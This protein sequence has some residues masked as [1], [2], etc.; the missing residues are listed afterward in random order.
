MSS[1][2]CA[3]MVP[4]NKHLWLNCSTCI[5]FKKHNSKNSQFKISLKAFT[6]KNV[7]TP[8]KKLFIVIR[9]EESCQF[10]WQHSMHERFFHVC[11]YLE[12]Q[13]RLSEASCS[14]MNPCSFQAFHCVLCSDLDQFIGTLEY[15]VAVAQALSLKY[16]DKDWWWSG[17][18]V[19]PLRKWVLESC[20]ISTGDDEEGD[21]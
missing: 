11:T 13:Q 20:K 21:L 15:L 14:S 9:L 2:S 6:L 7:N 3:G 12:K 4:T 18:Y 19:Q 16:T 17:K 10:L 5:L 1:L 8:I